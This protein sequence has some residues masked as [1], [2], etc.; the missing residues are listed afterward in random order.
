MKMRLHYAI[1][2]LF[3]LLASS[4]GKEPLESPTVL[5]IE[6]AVPIEQELLGMVNNYRSSLGYSS[7][8]FS[9]VAYDYANEH[10][11]YMIAKGNINHDGFSSRA[12]NISTKVDA[13]AVAE[14]VAK[15]YP[16]AKVA[17]EKWLASSDHLKNIVGNYTHTAVSV[18]KDP[19]GHYYYT[20]MFYR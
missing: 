6:N 14:N 2:V 1:L 15:D 17:F 9:S 4:C 12:S 19:S 13:S 20:Q 5:E 18:K 7:L 3:V 10:T 8:E 16:S 11:D